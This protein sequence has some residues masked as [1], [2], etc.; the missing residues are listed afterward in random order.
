MDNAG[1]RALIV[2]CVRDRRST[3]WTFRTFFIL[4]GFGGFV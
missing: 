1:L 2:G 4:F 3:A